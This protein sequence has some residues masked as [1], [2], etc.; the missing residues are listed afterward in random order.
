MTTSLM[1]SRRSG[2]RST[3]MNGTA[4]PT[5]RSRIRGTAS[6]AGANVNVCFSNSAE[7]GAACI[8]AKAYRATFRRPKS[9]DDPRPRTGAE[10]MPYSN[11]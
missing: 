8:G 5:T 4:I 7:T 11:G 6:G 10:P 9:D 3:S 1:T 2:I